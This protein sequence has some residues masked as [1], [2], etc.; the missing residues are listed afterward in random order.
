MSGAALLLR[1][2]LTGLAGPGVPAYLTFY[3]AVM[4]TAML[5]GLGP[6]LLATGASGLLAAYYILPPEGFPVGSLVDALGL[7][8]FSAMGLFMCL[9]AEWYR[10]ARQQATAA[11]ATLAGQAAQ[12]RAL[13]AQLTAAEQR[14]R[15]RVA[16]VLH[17]TL[18]QLLVGMKLLVSPLAQAADPRVR[19]VSQELTALINESLQ[20]AR[21]LTEDLSPPILLRGGLVPALEW[22]VQWMAEKHH[23]TV[24]LKAEAA[25]GGPDQD[26]TVL[27]FQAVRELLFNAVKHAQVQTV[28]VE[29][30]RRNAEVRVR[31]ADAGVGFDPAT[32]R[33]GGGKAGGFG[34]FSL[35]ERLE[36]LGGRLE[37]DSAPGK[38]SRITLAAPLEH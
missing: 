14:E 12:L 1:S 16:M 4:L 15:Q 22:L 7:G 28:Q 29:V 33:V 37:I 13:T 20:C 25:D 31:V 23:L 2:A 36:L 6:G 26:L 11:A 38:G 32:L 24:V 21:T 19:E 10:R 27:L 34:L 17:D 8:I 30:T 9:V 3:P 35:R 5:Y 18:Q